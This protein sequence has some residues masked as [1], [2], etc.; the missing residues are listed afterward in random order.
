MHIIIVSVTVSL[1]KIQLLMIL[2]K[3]LLTELKKIKKKN[4]QKGNN[5]FFGGPVLGG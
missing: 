2:K 4:S 1:I 3:G 5:I